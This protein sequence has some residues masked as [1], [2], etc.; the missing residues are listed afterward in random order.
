VVCVGGLHILDDGFIWERRRPS[1]AR[2]LGIT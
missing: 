1:V 2:T